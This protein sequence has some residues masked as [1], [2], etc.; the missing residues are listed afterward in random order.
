M[1][2]MYIREGKNPPS[3][4]DSGR[5]ELVGDG[6]EEE[7]GAGAKERAPEDYGLGCMT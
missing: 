3:A 7:G 1:S 6:R 4:S 5:Q 2:T